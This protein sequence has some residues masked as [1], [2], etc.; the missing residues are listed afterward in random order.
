MRLL[1]WLLL[2]YLGYR[3]IKGLANNRQE[4]PTIRKEESETYRDPVCGVYVTAEDAVVGRL[5]EQRI[6]FCSRSCLEKYQ[7][8][9]TQNNQPKET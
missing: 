5:G 9:L 8:S 1:I 2:I 4:Q 6:H 3:L 7:D